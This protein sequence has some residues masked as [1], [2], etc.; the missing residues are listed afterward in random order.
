MITCIV[1]PSRC[2]STWL[3]HIIDKHFQ[4]TGLN[5]YS[6]EYEIIDHANG[7]EV[8]KNPPTKNFLF[9]YQYLYANKPLLGAD[10]YIV[11]DR[12]DLHAWVYSSYMSF[13]NQHPHGAK[14]KEYIFDQAVFDSHEKA[15]MKLRKESWEPE[16]TRLISQGA[17]SLVYEDIKDLS[18]KEILKL[19]G[20]EDATEFDT[21]DLYLNGV[22]LEKVWS[23]PKRI[24][25]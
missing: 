3:Q 21:N 13:Q 14:P 16:K 9:K 11:L 15:M 17:T 23:K 7:M 24:V 19:C 6:M 20:Y 8:I 12:R 4:L 10:K 22:K 18:S 5:D 2:G 25:L 1:N